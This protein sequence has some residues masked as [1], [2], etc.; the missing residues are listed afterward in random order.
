MSDHKIRDIVI[1]G[2]GTAGWMAAAA[3][4]KYLPQDQTS[5]TLIESEEI[6]TIGVGEATIPQIATFNKML[7]IDEDEFVRETSGSFKLGI[8]FVNW[9]GLGDRYFHPFGDYGFDLEGIEFHQYWARLRGLGDTHSLDDYSLNATAAYA[10]KFIRPDGNPRSVTSKIGYAYHFDAT[11]YAAFLRRFAQARGVRRVEG[12]VTD[13]TLAQNGNIDSVTLAD[14]ALYKGDLFLDCTG[15]RGVLIEGALKAGYLDWSNYLP[16]DRAVAVPCAITEAPKPYTIATAR[17]AG[18][19]WRIPLQH[20][21]GNGHVY[22][23]QY[24]DQAVATDVLLN[25]IDGEPLADPRHLRFVTG[26]RKQFWKANCVAL[27]LSAGFLEPLESTSIHLIQSGIA[28]LLALFPDKRFNPVE[29]DEYNRLLSVSYEHIRDFILLHY[30]ATERDDT[31]FWRHMRDM[32]LPGTLARKMA[33]M[34]ERGRFFRYED[35][36]FSVTSWLAVLAGQRRAPQSHNPV[37]DV[38][39]EHNLTQSLANMRDVVAKTAA[40]M[41]THQQ[42]IDRFCK[43]APIKLQEPA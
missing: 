13:V 42:F 25:A 38:L 7:G 4:S 17:E 33:L 3:L 39:S 8:E 23:S 14:T 19:T 30:V 12:K 9:G 43:A 24:T 5:I 36:L 37:A 22:C 11:L 41:P 16:M 20:R 35:E 15:F 34:Q 31:P 2:G 27:G 1:V 10:G 26:R 21:V 6:G 32:E 18:W 29:R 40:A 28:K